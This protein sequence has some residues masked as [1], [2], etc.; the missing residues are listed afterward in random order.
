MP[1]WFVHNAPLFWPLIVGLGIGA[2][3]VAVLRLRDGGLDHF[4]LG[5]IYMI[6]LLLYLI[7][8]LVGFTWND[9]SFTTSNDLRLYIAQPTTEE[10]GYIAWLYIT[11][12][13]SFAAV[14]LL[15]RGTLKSTR[16]VVVPA[17][18]GLL[19]AAI[20]MYLAIVVFQAVVDVAFD[21]R[22]SDYQETYL[23]TRRLPLL[24][25]QIY[26]HLG[27]A[28]FVVELVALAMLFRRFDQYKVLIFIW[29]AMI[30]LLTLA[31]LGQRTQMVLSLLAAAMTYH[32]LVK[33]I[34]LK[35]VAIG[36]TAL[37]TVFTIHGILRGMVFEYDLDP[38]ANLFT[39]NSEFEALFAN[40]YDLNS[41]RLR[42]ELPDLPLAFFVDDF[43][44]VVPQQISPF[45]RINPSFWYVETFYPEF[46]DLGGGL[47]F[48]TIAEG[49][50][51]WGWLSLVLRG[52]VQGALFAAIYRAFVARQR[53]FWTFVL[54]VW[55]TA[56]A[57]QCFRGSTF[58]LVPFF[59]YRFVPVYIAL[60]IVNVAS[61]PRP[62]E[63]TMV[64]VRA[65]AT[66]E[67]SASP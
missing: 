13:A 47:A 67:A 33:P 50:V 2:L 25:A 58:Y 14:Y 53:S 3:F 40:A 9:A 18:D 57:Y 49:I 34:S 4:E 59:F 5:L 1:F 45:Q 61:G 27:G 30:T 12:L 65:R 26:S 38:D 39:Y 20:S 48:G 36:G 16:R 66:A 32:Y 41:R 60:R 54:Y 17:D 35:M 46:A 52:A 19:Y 43:L 24:L 6:S 56:Q 28:K 31:S 21:L 42:D 23:L 55:I 15:V 51:G 22:A 10:L 64:P 62:T 7:Y 37:L 8:P 29:L 11:H 44:A 63:R